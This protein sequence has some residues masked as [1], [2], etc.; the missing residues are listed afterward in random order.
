MPRE[1]DPLL[2]SQEWSNALYAAGICDSELASPAFRLAVLRQVH[3]TS[4]PP[5]SLPPPSQ[6]A[7]STFFL[8]IHHL[9]R[10]GVAHH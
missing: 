1:V 5:Q 2:A 3:R 6:I 4:N 9:L 7:G 10:Y 8:M